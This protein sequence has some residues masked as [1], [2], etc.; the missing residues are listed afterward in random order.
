MLIDDE[1]AAAE[2]AVPILGVTP[3]TL[4]AALDGLPTA[5]AGYAAACLYKG[6]AGEVFLAPRETGAL[7]AVL[8]GTGEGAGHEPFAT[9]KLA[10]LLPPG[11]Y[12]LAGGFDD[13]AL[14]HARV[15]ARR[16]QIH[17]LPQGD[18]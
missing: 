12:E 15:R 13:L 11:D 5:A 14:C 1:A 17:A 6:E 18:P 10:P 3:A 8:V 4:R 7:A 2:N 16:L 9:G